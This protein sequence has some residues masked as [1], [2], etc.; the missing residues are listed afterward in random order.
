[1][2]ALNLRVFVKL[3]EPELQLSHPLRTQ[4]GISHSQ[5]AEGGGYNLIGPYSIKLELSF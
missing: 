4:D 2:L 3:G 5:I 1:M